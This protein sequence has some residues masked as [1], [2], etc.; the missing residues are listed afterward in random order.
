MTN[1]DCCM[2]SYFF[3]G[4]FSKKSILWEES[5]IFVFF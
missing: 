1:N 3:V 2:F 5:F 4:Y